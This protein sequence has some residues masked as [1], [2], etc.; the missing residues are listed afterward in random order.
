MKYNYL[1]ILSGLVLSLVIIEVSKQL[2]FVKKEGM[3]N[4]TPGILPDSE[5]KGLLSDVYEMK[6]KPGVS[7]LNSEQLYHYYPVFPSKSISNNNIRY[8]GSPNNGKCSPG[9]LCGGLYKEKKDV[10]KAPKMPKRLPW[11]LQKKRVNYYA[12][13]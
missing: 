2:F 11:D 1:Y 12:S 10:A 3:S 13:N 8:W 6:E 9:A 5:T 4:L 7:S